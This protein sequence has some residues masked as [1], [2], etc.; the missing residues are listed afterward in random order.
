MQSFKTIKYKT[1]LKIKKLQNKI[2]FKFSFELAFD[3]RAYERV[4]V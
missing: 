3:S 2:K 4:S 1:V